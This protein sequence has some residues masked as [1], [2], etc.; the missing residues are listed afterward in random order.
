M[1]TA[2]ILA[3]LAVVIFIGIRSTVK[4]ASSG[5]CGA[6]EKVRRIRPSDPDRSHYPFEAEIAVDGM[7]CGGCE[8]K[9]SNALNQLNGVYATA[10]HTTGTV[11]VLLKERT[12]DAV[13]RNAVNS[14]GPYVAST[15]TWI[16]K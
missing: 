11:K 13:L 9:V 2:V 1:G 10:D 7:M 4:R 8:T 14:I 12:D 5:C 3:I 16:K 15:V 6:G